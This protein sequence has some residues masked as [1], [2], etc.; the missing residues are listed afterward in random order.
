MS[1]T[2]SSY[3]FIPVRHPS[4]QNRPNAAYTIL[5]AYSTPI[6]KGTPVKIVATTGNEINVAGATDDFIG[7]FIGVEYTDA[8]GVPTF[9]NYWPGTTTGATNIVAYV[10]DD[11]ETVFSCQAD[12]SIASTS[13]GDQADCSGGTY[14]IGTGS[15]GTGL[16]TAA[17]SS[18]LKGSGQ[19]GRW[20]IVDVDRSVDNAWGDTYTKVLVKIAAHQFVSD[21]T[22]I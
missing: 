16:S 5:A 8:N 10:C 21:K 18:T 1:S 7:V 2:L 6:Y 11:P 19:Q 9:S 3:G 20:R 14:S 22:A 13:V 12:G 15:T 4:G 17:L